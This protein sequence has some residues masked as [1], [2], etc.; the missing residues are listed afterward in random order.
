[1]HLT[2]LIEKLS[3]LERERAAQHK[4]RCQAS[5]DG[6]GWEGLRGSGWSGLITREARSRGGMEYSPTLL[7]IARADHLCLTIAGLQR[8]RAFSLPKKDKY[9]QSC[10]F[11]R[12][13]TAL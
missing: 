6:R 1:M 5:R 7:T 8:S 10:P 9:F 4:D 3:Q 11:I 13:L 2:L 12:S